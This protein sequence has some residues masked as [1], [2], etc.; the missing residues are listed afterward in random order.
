M[1][2]KSRFVCAGCTCVAFEFLGNTR[3]ATLWSKLPSIRQAGLM[4]V[5]P[6]K[7]HLCCVN[8]QKM[9][10]CTFL[11]QMGEGSDPGDKVEGLTCSDFQVSGLEGL[12]QGY[13][14]LG[15]SPSKVMDPPP[16]P[17]HPSQC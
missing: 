1:V 11:R 15:G 8:C 14:T 5:R 4:D 2:I 9:D 16:N 3:H 6:R 17:S 12:C 10:N 7:W 13:L